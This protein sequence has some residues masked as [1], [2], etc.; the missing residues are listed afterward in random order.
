MRGPCVCTHHPLPT[1]ARSLHSCLRPPVPPTLTQP[2]GPGL[3]LLAPDLLV[4]VGQWAPCPPSSL[5]RL[6]HH[7]LQGAAPNHMAELGSASHPVSPAF[8]VLPP[9]TLESSCQ[10]L[11][12]PVLGDLPS[13]N[14]GRRCSVLLFWLNHC[15]K[16]WWD[17]HP[18]R[19]VPLGL[20]FTHLF[21]QQTCIKLLM[22]GRHVSPASGEAQGSSLLGLER[23]AS[24]PQPCP[25]S[26]IAHFRVVSCLPRRALSNGISVP[27]RAFI[28]LEANQ[29]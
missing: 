7:L 3:A 18:A 27:L 20:P 19:T 6:Q 17:H 21:T 28:L 8:L 10:S 26:Q 5:P 16:D 1:E 12:L 4:C 14:T 22:H 29:N 11:L 15:V 9:T 2:Q 25:G 24:S 13:P 23:L